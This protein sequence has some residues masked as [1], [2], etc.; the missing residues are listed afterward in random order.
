MT[1]SPLC[2]ITGV[3]DATGSATVRKFIAE[4]YRVAM[5]ARNAKRLQALEKVHP[6]AQTYVCDISD[7]G[8]FKRCLERI[9]AE[10]GCPAVLVH[11]AVSH[12]FGRFRGLDPMQIEANFRVNTT[13]LLIFARFFADTML[14]NGGG[15]ILATGN[16]A[17]HRGV[18]NYALFAPTKAAQRSLCEALARDLGPEGIHVCYLSID[19]AID[20]TWLGTSDEDRPAWLT[21]PD[22]WPHAREDYFAHPDGIAA[23]IYHLTHQ[24]KTTWAFEYT[25]RPFAE[26]W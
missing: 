9:E 15:A 24:H 16:T 7:L 3:G 23:E 8:R 14:A 4:G 26:K 21:P 18:P 10:M 6:G 2:I 19:A 11:N 12:A 25:I 13:A 20:A 5:I 17:S 22:D 1:T